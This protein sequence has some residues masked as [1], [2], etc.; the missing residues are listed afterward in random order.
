MDKSAVRIIRTI[1]TLLPALS[2]LASGA[3]AAQAGYIRIPPWKRP[4]YG[5]GAEGPDRR[6]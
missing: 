5:A 3:Y 2:F 4:D 1:L 6:E